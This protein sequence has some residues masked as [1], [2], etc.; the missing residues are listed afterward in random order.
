MLIKVEV[1][2]SL[3]YASIALT[4]VFWLVFIAVTVFILVSALFPQVE[5][6][7]A[8]FV[9]APKGETP[10]AAARTTAFEQ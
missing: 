5:N 2:A 10:P 9:V 6:A 1:L 8:D 4:V 3:I 7:Y